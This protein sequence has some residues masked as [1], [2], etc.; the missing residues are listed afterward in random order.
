MAIFLQLFFSFRFHFARD[1]TNL[2]FHSLVK[3]PPHTLT[4]ALIAA[5]SGS[6]LHPN[7]KH[8]AAGKETGASGEKVGKDIYSDYGKPEKDF[9]SGIASTPSPGKK[10][11]V[12]VEPEEGLL[13]AVSEEQLDMLSDASPEFSPAAR[14]KRGMEECRADIVA[15]STKGGVT[16][17]EKLMGGKKKPDP[18]LVSREEG[19]K[20]I[21]TPYSIDEKTAKIIGAFYDKLSVK[22]FKPEDCQEMEKIISL[23]P[24]LPM[25][26]YIASGCWQK[27]GDADRSVDHLEKELAVNPSHAESHLAIADVLLHKGAKKEAME[28]VI[29]AVYYY[30]AWEVP[31][32]YLESVKELGCRI[33]K[34]PFDPE[35]FIEVGPGG[36]VAAAWPAQHPWLRSYAVCKAAFRYCPEVR[37]SF[38]MK[39][40]PYKLSVMEELACLTLT[41]EAYAASVNAGAAVD[42]KG[43]RLE[44]AAAGGELVPFA[45]F[46]IIGRFSPDYMKFLPKEVRS[47]IMDY[48]GTFVVVD[49]SGGGPCNLEG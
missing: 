38:G 41:R 35:I 16:N 45:L 44:K 22:D 10:K 23:D 15:V 7:A 28:E 34:S 25:L 26:H 29:T 6:C 20:I 12:H 14:L 47:S 5:L 48:I 13:L 40:S 11:A 31:A 2:S 17:F 24:G 49:E 21:A 4:V 27:V 37:M 32:K 18:F 30:P 8:P 42:P 19:G 9:I 33:Q 1:C 43:E 46:E 36:V 3:K 39:A